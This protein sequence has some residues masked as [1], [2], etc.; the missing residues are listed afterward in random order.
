MS[1]EKLHLWTTISTK[2]EVRAVFQR[3][4]QTM[5][6]DKTGL[7]VEPT[8]RLQELQEPD[9]KRASHIKDKAKR[10]TMEGNNRQYY[11]A[12]HITIMMTNWLSQ[13]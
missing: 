1:R 7:T 2:H 3:E 4:K 10:E 5:Q 6:Q 12:T 13:C 11:T 9:A 8:E